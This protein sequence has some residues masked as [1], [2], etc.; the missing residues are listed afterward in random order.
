MTAFAEKHFMDGLIKVISRSFHNKVPNSWFRFFIKRNTS[1][2]HCAVNHISL[3][4][5]STEVVLFSYHE[6]LSPVTPD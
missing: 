1:S 2:T 3:I 6:N 4:P 5:R